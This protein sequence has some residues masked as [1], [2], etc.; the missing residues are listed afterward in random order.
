MLMNPVSVSQLPSDNSSLPVLFAVRAEAMA[1]VLLFV[2]ALL[3][4]VAMIDVVPLS[5][6]EATRAYSA[7]HSLHPNSPG[8]PA[9]ADSA[10]TFWAQ[11]LAFVTL[12]GSEFT[13]RLGGVVAGLLLGALALLFR[14]RLGVTRTL[15]FSVLLLF[16]PITLAASRTHDPALWGACCALLAAWSAWQL[17]DTAT[18]A[19]AVWLGIALGGLAFLSGGA[20]LVYLLVLLLASGMLL[21]WS[22]RK[23]PLAWDIPAS[24]LLAIAHERARA[25]SWRA[26]VLATVGVTLFVSTGM[27]FYPTGLTIVAQSLASAL[28]GWWQPANPTAPAFYPFWILATYHLAFVLMG[29]VGY[30][31][32]ARRSV[33]QTSDRFAVLVA[34]VSGGVLAV[35][36]GATAGMTLWVAV[37]LAWIAAHW[38]TELLVDRAD[39]LYWL[40]TNDDRR[41]YLAAHGWVK[42]LIAL[43]ALVLLA[44]MSFHWQAIGR[45]VLLVNTADYALLAERLIGEPALASF[46]YSAVWF[47]VMA[48]FSVLLG[49]LAASVWGSDAMWQGLGWGFFAFAFVSGLGGGWNATQT[50]AYSEIWDLATTHQDTQMLRRTLYEVSMRDTRGNPD[51]PVV[52]LL[53]EEDGITAHGLVAWLLRDYPNARFVSTLA[54]ARRQQVVLLPRPQA[55][56]LDLGGSYVGQSF[57]LRSHYRIDA[58]DPLRVMGWLAQRRTLREY[59]THDDS[60]LWLRMDVYDGV[61]VSQRLP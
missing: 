3:L 19:H 13:A 9:P 36:Q 34:L 59:F 53:S 22:M 16:N 28:T 26:V 47:V 4:R 21:W 1:Y 31:F 40:I 45:G 30:V 41:R 44:V 6:A 49:L 57:R 27:M 42:W 14:G 39:S 56:G 18:R 58:L 32:L 43:V 23:A 38:L 33:T 52:V 51:L 55:Q 50:Q 24:R 10:L 60:I 48:I 37:P 46:R 25:V 20:G 5:E 54:D 29:V 8:V 17:W 12:G 2:L 61:P 15:F 35:Y 11:R 7:W